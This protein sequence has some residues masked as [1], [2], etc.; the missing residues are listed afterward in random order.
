MVTLEKSIEVE[1]PIRS[2]YNQWTQFEEFPRFMEGVEEVRQLDDK[3]L[4][5][6][7]KVGGKEI[8][9]DAEITQQFP[10]QRIDWRSTSGTT[11]AGSISFEPVDQNRTRIVLR[12]EY[13]PEGVAEIV[14]SLLGV[15]SARIE[16]DLKRFK[17]FIE[18][19]GHETG[20]WRGEIQ[21]GEVVATDADRTKSARNP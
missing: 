12:L 20:G 9:W 16:G 3:R 6:R 18:A 4:H 2:V 7:A 1:A 8:E 21:K 14:A 5:W 15:T 13:D 11:N 19:R 10:D 17:E